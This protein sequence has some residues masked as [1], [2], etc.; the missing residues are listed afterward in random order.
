MRLLRVPGAERSPVS[1][2]ALWSLERGG[3]LK[4]FGALV[5]GDQS[6]QRLAVVT[7]D[8]IRGVASGGILWDSLADLLLFCRRACFLTVESPRVV[9][10][11]TFP[12]L[13]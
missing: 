5:G 10:S 13:N 4:T 7:R 8:S 1:P 12:G 11:V 9:W 2:F 6:R 3:I